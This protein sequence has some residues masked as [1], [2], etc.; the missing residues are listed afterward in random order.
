VPQKSFSK[1]IN[2]I[3]AP[4]DVCKKNNAVIS[5]IF[6]LHYLKLIVPN[7]GPELTEFINLLTDKVFIQEYI[8]KI[9]EIK[10]TYHFTDK[11]CV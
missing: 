3:Y 5:V 7:L 8:K 2:N 10:R 4:A 9:I 6:K 1:H 11:P